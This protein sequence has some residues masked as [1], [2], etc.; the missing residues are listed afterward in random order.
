MPAGSG[1]RRHRDTHEEFTFESG[2]GG[3]GFITAGAGGSGRG[4]EADHQRD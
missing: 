1:R 2:A 3:P 4:I